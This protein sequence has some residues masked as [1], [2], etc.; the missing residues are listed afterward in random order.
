MTKGTMTA[1]DRIFNNTDIRNKEKR[2]LEVKLA[3]QGCDYGECRGC[4]A[5]CPFSC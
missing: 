1:P 3:E 5:D 2:E 4:D